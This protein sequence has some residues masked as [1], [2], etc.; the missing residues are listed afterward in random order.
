MPSSTANRPTSP[1]P[2]RRALSR[3]LLQFKPSPE[4]LSP[5]PSQPTQVTAGIKRRTSVCRR[6][7]SSSSRHD[8]DVENLPLPRS[9]IDQTTT[10]SIKSSSYSHENLKPKGNQSKVDLSSQSR[11]S[12]IQEVS[13]SSSS[14]QG[15]RQSRPSNITTPFNLF[16]SNSSF[17]QSSNLNNP[18]H[19]TDNVNHN[20]SRKFSAMSSSSSSQSR[21]ST[22]SLLLP[23]WNDFWHGNSTSN[24]DSTSIQARPRKLQRKGSDESFFCIQ[25]KGIQ[26]NGDENDDGRVAIEDGNSLCL[27]DS[28]SSNGLPPPRPARPHSFSLFWDDEEAM[29]D[30]LDFSNYKIETKESSINMDEQQVVRSISPTQSLYSL[31]TVSSS[32]SLDAYSCPSPTSSCF[33]SSPKEWFESCPPSPP[34]TIRLNLDFSKT[35]HYR[36]NG[37]LPES[38][39]LLISNSAS[40]LDLKELIVKRLSSKGIA[41]SPKELSLQIPSS[42]PQPLTASNLESQGAS[43]S[44]IS[45]AATLMDRV[46]GRNASEKRPASSSTPSSPISPSMIKA[47]LRELE[48][49]RLI[50][51][52]GLL[53]D[54]AVLVSLKTR[55]LTWIWKVHTS[56]SVYITFSVIWRRSHSYHFIPLA[57][58]CL[59]FSY[60][61]FLSRF[62]F[63]TSLSTS[64]IRVT[65]SLRIFLYQVV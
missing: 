51:E 8:H 5:S 44:P 32:L 4:S 31:S 27:T 29:A 64:F 39:V 14:P 26:A 41:F 37:G 65:S 17:I 50:C 6:P 21:P 58:L 46:R 42:Q 57:T 55:T 62:T 33:P 28:T 19:Q 15:S 9:S 23:A 60:F 24:L 38:E 12:L 22:P 18:H 20:H 13:S 54:D 53:E 63:A 56:I 52:E 34:A 43:P 11:L 2:L 7:S 1:N 10:T 59:A 45:R 25:A 16:L 47:Q 61:Y 30:R 3:S 40:I 35:S 36:S 48:N 49:D